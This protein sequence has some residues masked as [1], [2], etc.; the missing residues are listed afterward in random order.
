MVNIQYV[1]DGIERK[2]KE[3]KKKKKERKRRR[4]RKKRGLI[5]NSHSRFRFPHQTLIM[6]GLWPEI[7]FTVNVSSSNPWG[8]TKQNK[9]DKKTKQKQTKKQTKLW[10]TPDITMHVNI[11]LSNQELWPSPEI[12]MDVNNYLSIHCSVRTL[13]KPGKYIA[14]LNS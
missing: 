10:L 5:Q 13:A 2:K 3:K 12:T 6:K 4:R 9:T 1:R 14:Y 7:A 8:K 11:S